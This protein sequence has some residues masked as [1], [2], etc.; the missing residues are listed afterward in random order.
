[1]EIRVRFAPSPTGYL[2]IG[3]AR[4]ALFNW[5]FARNTGGKFILRIEDTDEVRSTVESVKA[6]IDSLKWLGLD[7]DEGPEIVSKSSGEFVFESRGDF[8]P[9]FQMERQRLGIYQEFAQKLINS[10]FAYYCYCTAEELAEKRQKALKE[11]RPPKYDGTCRNLTEQQIALKKSLGIKPVLRFKMPSEGKVE[12]FDIIRGNLVFENIL[13]D[14]FVLLKASGVP[15]YNFACVV[16]D[17]LMKI[18]YVIRGDDHLSN[19]P[20]Q[21]HLYRAL[22]IELPRFVHLS[23]ILGP[24][25][26][27]LSKRH[28]HTSVLEY[29]RDGYLAEALL[30]YLAL[31][32]WATEDS[33]QIFSKEELIKKFSLERCG[34]SPAIF[35]GQKLL[36]MNGEYIRKKSAQELVEIFRHWAYVNN[37]FPETKNWDEGL[38]VRA[39]AA[40]R[41]KIKLL[42]EIPYLVDFFFAN[43]IEYNEDARKVLDQDGVKAILREILEILVETADYS[44][45]N[46][47]KIIRQYCERKNCKTSFVFHPLRAAVS[48]RT[49]GPHLFEMLEILGKDKVVER[50]K[51]FLEKNYG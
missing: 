21:V 14:D 36:W 7:W 27:R 31:L 17:Y 23:M 43:N 49:K 4:T 50:L 51:K 10:G 25:G 12:F 44:A 26:T 15:T 16:D 18:N 47:E 45:Q 1:M 2:H 40:E 30:N 32:G 20:R 22:G 46:L 41:E 38:F 42:K 5:L 8:G 34:K 39:V 33:Q 29:A 28:G 9:Y 6:I 48:G 3:G 11:K 24:D 35:D 13:L 37:V 19:T